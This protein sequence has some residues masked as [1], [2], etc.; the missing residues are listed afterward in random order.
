LGLQPAL[1]GHEPAGLL[2]GQLAGANAP[3]NALPLILLRVVVAPIER[4]GRALSA[5]MIT[6]PA[7]MIALPAAVRPGAG[8][9]AGPVMPE[10][11]LAVIAL[12]VNVAGL[13]LVIP[14]HVLALRR[15]R[16]V[17]GTGRVLLA[18]CIARLALELARITARRI[19][20]LRALLDTLLL[21]LLALVGAAALALGR[22]HWHRSCDQHCH[23]QTA[24]HCRIHTVLLFS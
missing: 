17:S 9:I 13:P 4:A 11:A 24:H 2:A 3:L 21:R 1:F 14:L 18:P 22:R 15:V 23:Q 12:A 5:V 7:V 16:T 20:L 6:L 19:A 10:A 8:M